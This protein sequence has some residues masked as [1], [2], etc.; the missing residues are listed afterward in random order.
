ML[1]PVESVPSNPSKHPSAS[2]ILVVDDEKPSGELIATLLRSQGYVVR[3]VAAGRDALPILARGGVDLVLLDL[4]MSHM[5]GVEIC[6][7]VR[8]ELR[9]PL[10]PIVITTSLNDRE[11]RIRAKEAGADDVLVKPIDGL[12]LLVRIESLLRA[13][14]HV[15]QLAHER[16]RLREE[17]A[18]ART[19]IGTQ[20]RALRTI[21]DAN[22]LLHALLERQRLRLEGAKKRWGNNAEAREEVQRFAQIA[23]ELAQTLELV[24]GAASSSASAD[25]TGTHA[26]DADD[27]VRITA[28]K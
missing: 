22:E 18:H 13:R 14:A 7:H 28:T 8:N 17:L 19:V 3:L 12:E 11:S 24:A 16:D 15:G 1:E 25:A 23:L 10:L 2:S 6:A 5:D 9:D 21:E 4:M 26:V 20:Q 27:R